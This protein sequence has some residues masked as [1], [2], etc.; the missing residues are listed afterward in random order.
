MAINNL[1]DHF[2]IYTSI[3]SL[4][5][6][7]ETNIMLYVNYSSIRTNKQKNPT[8]QNKNNDNLSGREGQGAPTLSDPGGGWAVRWV[9]EARGPKCRDRI[10]EAPPSL[11]AIL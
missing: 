6:T 11:C 5:C 9:G 10:T 7:P 2:T 3:E 8:K 4:C 1:G